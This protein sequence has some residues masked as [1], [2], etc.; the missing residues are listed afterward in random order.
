MPL[1]LSLPEHQALLIA[2]VD[3]AGRGPLAGAVYAAAVIL[4]PDHLLPGIDDSKKLTEH[5]RE[6][7]YPQILAHALCYA[8]ASASVAE[9][10][11]LNI[12]QASLLAMHR[13]VTEL[14]RQP[15]FV[16]VDG[17]HCPRWQYPS[18]AF[19]KGDS[20][21]GA[22]AA[23]SVLAKVCRDREMRELDKQFPGYGFAVHKGYPTPLHLETLQKYGPCAVHRKTFKP[24]AACLQQ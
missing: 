19:V 21:F 24:V 17:L 11:T 7:L 23:A 18:Q 22:I 8:V 10:E 9:I 16:Y 1:T 4:N 5:Q 2:G 12:L 13:A 3:E 6:E 20:R 14:H 15:E